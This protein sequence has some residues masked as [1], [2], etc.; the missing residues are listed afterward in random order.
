MDISDFVHEGYPFIRIVGTVEDVMAKIFSNI[1]KPAKKIKCILEFMSK[2]MIR[3]TA[4][5]KVQSIQ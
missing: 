1:I 3:E 5:T 4:K 2:F